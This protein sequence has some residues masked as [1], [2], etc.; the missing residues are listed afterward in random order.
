MLAAGPAAQRR[1]LPD[2]TAVVKYLGSVRRAMLHVL[3]S[4]AATGSVLDN[5]EALVAYLFASMAH[6]PAEQLRVLFLNS[7]NRLLRDEAL[8]EGS[9]SELPIQARQILIRALEVGAAGLIL[10][11]NHPSGDPRPSKGDIQA[12][13][14][15]ADAA[16]ALE[17]L[18]HD[19]IIVARSGWSSFRELGLI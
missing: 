5:T 17:I 6:A 3:R 16:R 15:I 14:R 8:A 13:R 2:A 4:N 1:V 7:K 11:H 19:H 18:V 9:I 12:T 10:V